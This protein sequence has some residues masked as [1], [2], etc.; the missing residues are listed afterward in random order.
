MSKFC[1]N[2][3]KIIPLGV[4]HIEVRF[5]GMKD[6]ERLFKSSQLDFCKLTC[7]EE[8]WSEK[9]YLKRKV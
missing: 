9:N 3:N 8:Y 1:D 2:C 4:N 5:I 7:L 6:V